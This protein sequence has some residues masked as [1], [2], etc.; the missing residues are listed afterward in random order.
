VIYFVEMGSDIMIYLPSFI[1]I[2]PGIQ[3]SL[4]EDAHTG[5]QTLINTQTARSSQKHAF[6]FA[7]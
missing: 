5:T 1:K 4:G 3:K 6:V 7:K 2:G